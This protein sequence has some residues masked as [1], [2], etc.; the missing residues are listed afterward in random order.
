MLVNGYSSGHSSMPA[1]AWGPPGQMDPDSQAWHGPSEKGAYSPGS[2]TTTHASA[3]AASSTTVVNPGGQDRR[4]VSGP[5]WGP[6]GQ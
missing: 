6:P 2:H 4:S 1:L 5:V 3:P